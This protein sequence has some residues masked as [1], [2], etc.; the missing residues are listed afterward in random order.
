M[1][2]II[3][4]LLGILF[5][6]CFSVSGNDADEYI[7]PDSVVILEVVGIPPELEGY[8]GDGLVS[9]NSSWCGPSP[10]SY[11]SGTICWYRNDGYFQVSFTPTSLTNGATVA[12]ACIY[13]YN[14]SIRV[15]CGGY[16]GVG[17]TSWTQNLYESTQYSPRWE[18][19]MF[20]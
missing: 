3:V 8:N 7:D 1:K 9:I 19:A 2:K 12:R 13:E 14:T 4:L 16:V 5:I 15:D 10:G 18:A 20:K 17:G 11:G 6:A